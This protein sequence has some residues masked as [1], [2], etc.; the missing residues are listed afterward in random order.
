MVVALVLMKKVLDGLLVALEV[1]LVGLYI[2][3]VLREVAE[4]TMN[5]AAGCPRPI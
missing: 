5:L 4:V 1:F 2:P 3:G